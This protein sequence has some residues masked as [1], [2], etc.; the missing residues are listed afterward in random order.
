MSVTLATFHFERSELKT[1]AELN[2]AEVPKE[3]KRE[4]K[5]RTNV[6]ISDENKNSSKEREEEK[7]KAG[8]GEGVEERELK[9]TGVHVSDL[10]HVPFREV[11]V[12]RFLVEK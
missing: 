6:L 12:E 10:G 8:C 2:T 4:Q 11:C 1:Q 5:K 3:R 9:R 7:K